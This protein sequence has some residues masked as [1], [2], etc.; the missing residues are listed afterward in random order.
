MPPRFKLTCLAVAL[1]LVLVVAGWLVLESVCIG[2]LVVITV[3]GYRLVVVVLAAAGF[4]KTLALAVEAVGGGWLV[5]VIGGCLLAV[6]A[7]IIVGGWL[8]KE[9]VGGDRLVIVEV[10]VIVAVGGGRLVVVVV[11][12]LLSAV[13]LTF[14]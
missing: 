12:G 5:N 2:S 11:G 7:F 13:A 8:V 6:V 10:G 4:K 14:C 1:D 3:S 9:V